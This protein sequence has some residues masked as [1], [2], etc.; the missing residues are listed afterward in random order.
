MTMER[1]NSNLIPALTLLFLVMNIFLFVAIQ[2]PSGHFDLENALRK[3]NQETMATPIGPS[4][5]ELILEWKMVD[6]YVEGEWRVEKYQEFEF[7][8]DEKGQKVKELPTDHFNYLRYW[9]YQ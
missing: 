1:T 5:P 6:Q 4:S 7:Y 3:E 9:R 8:Y 2:A